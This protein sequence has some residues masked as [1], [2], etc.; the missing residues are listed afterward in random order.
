MQTCTRTSANHTATT[1]PLSPTTSKP[2][3]GVA[4]GAAAS[5]TP[6]PKSGPPTFN[7]GP[8]ATPAAAPSS[9]SFGAKGAAPPSSPAASTTPAFSFGAKGADTPVPS[10]APSTAAAPSFIF[11]APA[12]PPSFT[13][14]SAS[15]EAAATPPAFNF[16]RLGPT[17][18]VAGA[19][20]KVPTFPT[21][22]LPAPSAL[23]SF[24]PPAAATTT[25]S[26]AA[27][28]EEPRPGAEGERE[29]EEEDT[30]P[31]E[32]QVGD[33]L[34]TGA[35]EE[36]EDTRFTVKCKLF[37]KPTATADWTPIGVGPLK[38]NVHRTSGRCRILHRAEGS[39]RILLNTLLFPG[40]GVSPVGT[41][42]KDLQFA[43]VHPATG[44]LVM[45]LA[46]VKQASDAAE[47]LRVMREFV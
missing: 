36:E 18:P 35:G 14:G 20:A 12:Q 42:G 1:S 23:S 45:H 9:F 41:G 26:G 39:G 43:I 19:T 33:A 5:S 21:F 30:F 17:P 29:G 6:A 46:R 38:L 4:T 32:E 2:A 27:A 47:M 7:F 10:A 8:V 13:F 37:S 11:G 24:L 15:T 28:G 31:A 22:G 16:A 44:G 34:M 3:Q 25:A 40:M